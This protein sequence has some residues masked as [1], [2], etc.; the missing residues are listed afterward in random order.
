MDH[1][2]LVGP[3]RRPADL[4]ALVTRGVNRYRSSSRQCA[5]ATVHGEHGHG[6]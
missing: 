1:F 5:V 2:G 3:A 4:T 6:S